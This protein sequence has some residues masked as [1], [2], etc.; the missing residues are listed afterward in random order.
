MNLE[1]YYPDLEFEIN[2]LICKLNDRHSFDEKEC[3]LN[4]ALSLL[5]KPIEQ[6]AHPSRS[7]A[8]CFIE[9]FLSEKNY[10]QAEDWIKILL[11]IDKAEPDPCDY[12][13][14]GK[15]YFDLD[16]LDMAYLYFDMAYNETKYY[17]FSMENKKYWQYYKF[18]KEILKKSQ[19][20]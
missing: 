9:L 6:W 20:R 12:M 2:D 7:I 3:L 11:S 14:A 8:R 5:P 16:K 1:D 13:C 4:Q 17:L 18:Q 19:Q 10:K 15:F